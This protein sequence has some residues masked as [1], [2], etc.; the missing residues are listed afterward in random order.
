VDVFGSGWE[1]ELGVVGLDVVGLGDVELP[2]E[3]VVGDAEGLLLV[4]LGIEDEDNL[5]DDEAFD[6]EG[7]C[8]GEESLDDKAILVD[9]GTCNIEEV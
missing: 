7:A 9:E 8:D 1:D 5:E 4:V 3:E 2:K 6:E